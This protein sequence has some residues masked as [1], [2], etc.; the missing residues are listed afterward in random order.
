MMN[1]I[2]FTL[3]AV[4]LFWVVGLCQAEES[5]REKLAKLDAGS[6]ARQP[7]SK[8]AFEERFDASSFVKRFGLLETQMKTLEEAG[9]NRDA[10][11]LGLETQQKMLQ[12]AGKTH[13][14]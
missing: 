8:S 12:E 13:D 2:K 10:R 14:T 3:M 1:K 11:I 5:L 7:E 4:L 9:K 6:K